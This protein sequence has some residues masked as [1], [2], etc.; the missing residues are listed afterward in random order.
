MAL[1]SFFFLIII[2]LLSPSALLPLGRSSRTKPAVVKLSALKGCLLFHTCT[3]NTIYQPKHQPRSPRLPASWKLCFSGVLSLVAQRF[4]WTKQVILG[5]WHSQ[6]S[7]VEP[8][9]FSPHLY[10]SGVLTVAIYGMYSLPVAALRRKSAFVV[11]V[12][13]GDGQLLLYSK[14][15]QWTFPGTIS[16]RF[17]IELDIICLNYSQHAFVPPN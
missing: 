5:C 17:S 1:C 10:D 16:W 2:L 3:R 13:V 8:V 4:P 6:P 15:L 14:N 12:A 11:A 9:C 7:C